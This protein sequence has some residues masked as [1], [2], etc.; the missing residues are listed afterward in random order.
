MDNTSRVQPDS[1]EGSVT[2]ADTND[3]PG[4]GHLHGGQLWLMIGQWPEVGGMASTKG[5]I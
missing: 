5:S 1:A 3:G 2:K 4:G